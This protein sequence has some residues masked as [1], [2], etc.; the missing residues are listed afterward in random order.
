MFLSDFDYDLP[1]ELIARFPA[2]ERRA[3]RLLVLGDDLQDRNFVDFPRLV[4]AV[5]YL[6]LTG[7]P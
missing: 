5:S 3:S 1:D 7:R 2:S 6:S 4:E